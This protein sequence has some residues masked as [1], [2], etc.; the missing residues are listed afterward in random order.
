MTGLGILPAGPRPGFGGHIALHLMHLDGA[1]QQD[2]NSVRGP[3]PEG[4]VVDV[5][6][7]VKDKVR[8]RPL[9][10]PQRYCHGSP[11]CALSRSENLESRDRSFGKRNSHCTV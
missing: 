11:D 10:T 4:K 7:G 1:R 3:C 6:S 5:P 8:S 2:A 9:V